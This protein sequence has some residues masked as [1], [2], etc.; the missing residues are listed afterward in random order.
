MLP[1]DEI[2][3]VDAQHKAFGATF[4]NV[5][6]EMSQKSADGCAC[7]WQEEDNQHEGDCESDGELVVGD[8]K[9]F[10]QTCGEKE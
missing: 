5:G 1:I 3:S 4:T 9:T 10:L 7:G 8:G 6:G 2:D